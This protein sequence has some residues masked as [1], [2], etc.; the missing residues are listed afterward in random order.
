MYNAANEYHR[1]GIQTEVAEADPHRLIQMLMEGALDRMAS[2]KGAMQ[3]NDPALKG[4]KLGAAISIIDALRASLDHQKGGEIAHNLSD[5][6]AYMLS[7]LIEASAS[8]DTAL[9]D[10][11]SELLR[12][13]KS[14]WDEVPARLEQ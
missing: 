2:A 3:Q 8:N 12:T 9:I 13:I 4:E 14:A 10:E 7:R 11:V 5:L 6:Y 1:L